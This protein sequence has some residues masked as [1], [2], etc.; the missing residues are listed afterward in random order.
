M[1]PHR[2][3]RRGKPTR[4]RIALVSPLPPKGSGISEYA[5]RLAGAGGDLRHRPLPRRGL[6]PPPG[7]RL[8]RVRLLRLS[9]LRAPGG[10]AGLSRRCVSDGQLRPLPFVPVRADAAAP[11]RG[12]L[13]RFQPGGVP[14]GVHARPRLDG[15]LPARAGVLLPGGL[16]RD[17]GGTGRLGPGMGGLARCL[18][19]AGRVPQPPALRARRRGGRALAVVSGPGGRAVSRAPGPHDG[20]PDGNPPPGPLRRSARRDPGAVRPAAAGSD[21]CQ[22][23]DPVARQDE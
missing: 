5:L 23:R 19:P 20:H 7:A 18:R 16:G 2:S 17:G 11:R 14:R 4:P 21:R 3:S 8:R 22:L 13:A 1:A 15:P 10:G 9:A 6:H 12:D